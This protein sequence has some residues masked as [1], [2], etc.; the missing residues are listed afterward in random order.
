[1]SIDID[2]AVSIL[3]HGGIIAFPTETVYGLGA[4]ATHEEAIQKVFVAKNRPQD[5]PL[6]CHFYS[7]DQI[8]EYV[9]HI[10]LPVKILFQNFSPGPLSILLDLP[11]N[12]PLLKATSGQPRVVCRIPS[13]PYALE[14]L[15]KIQIPLAAPSAN[16]SGKMSGTDIDMIEKDLGSAID[17]VIDG[18]VCSI[19]L[20]SIIIDGRSEDR[21]TILRPGSIGLEEIK[22]V[23]DSAYEAG[24]LEYL[25]EVLEVEKNTTFVVPGAKYRHYSPKTPVYGVCDW[26]NIP[27]IY[28]CAIVGTEESLQE[29]KNKNTSVAHTYISLGSRHDVAQI[30][31]NLYKSLYY[32]DQT[33]VSKAYFLVED[34]GNTSI[35]KA[36]YNRLQKILLDSK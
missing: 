25:V 33:Q 4:V 6:I 12:S 5:N 23:L 7:V 24:I 28:E 20:E 36:L 2:Q 11:K 8:A 22:K 1:M 35:A 32:I 13:H 9:T 15:Q 34:W 29:Y 21:I 31:K 26:K 18:G 3:Q 27:K 19:G 17:G 10:P 16:T 30:A 14:L